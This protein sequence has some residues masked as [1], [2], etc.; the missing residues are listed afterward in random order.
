MDDKIQ[1]TEIENSPALKSFLV[2]KQLEKEWIQFDDVEQTKKYYL[3]DHGVYEVYKNKV[4]SVSLYN[5][6]ELEEFKAKKGFMLKLAPKIN[7]PDKNCFG[8]MMN[9]FR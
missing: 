3:T 6:Q 9:F 4:L 8:L 5:K 1:R 7:V 2:Q